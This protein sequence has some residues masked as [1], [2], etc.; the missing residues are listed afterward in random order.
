MQNY[1]FLPFWGPSIEPEK[2]SVKSASTPYPPPKVKFMRFLL[3]RDPILSHA[4][5][6]SSL[7]V[8]CLC[9]CFLFHLKNDEKP[10]SFSF[11]VLSLGECFKLPLDHIE[12]TQRQNNKNTVGPQKGAFKAQS[13]SSRP[14]LSVEIIHYPIYQTKIGPRYSLS[15]SP[16]AEVV[17][18]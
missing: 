6:L 14:N 9:P 12:Y 7:F 16:S 17:M 8:F 4:M 1:R 2:P 11:V 13:N 18:V 15:S 5:E 3:I 10:N